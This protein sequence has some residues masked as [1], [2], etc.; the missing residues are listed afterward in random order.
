MDA[1]LGAA[2]CDPVS[3][4][5][6]DYRKARSG[7][8]E[9]RPA[10]PASGAS[11]LHSPMRYGAAMSNVTA[12]LLLLV[13]GH[14]VAFRAYYAI[15]DTVR[16]ATG[17]PAHSFYGFLN[18]LVRVLQDRA[19]THVAVTLDLGEPFRTAL[20]PAYK[21]SRSAGP[22]DLEPQ[23]A[24]LRTLL[25]QLGVPVFERQ[26]FEAD[27][28]LATLTRQGQARG[29]NVDVLS[30]D[31]DV[32][33]LVA[34]GVRIVTPGKTFAEPVVYDEAAVVGRYGV[35]P[36]KLRDWKALVGDA[37]DEI[38]GVPGIGKKTATELLQRYDSL[39]A[40][41]THLDH[42]VNTRA[43]NA[44]A[45]GR[46]SAE[47]SRMLVTLRTDAPVTLDLEA[48]RFPS[49]APATA[50]HAIQDLGFRS[51]AD[52]VARLAEPVR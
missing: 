1:W 12:P 6:L 32:L 41:Y 7:T 40:I 27:D 13:D 9:A 28:L 21:S 26:G 38:P 23:V 25:A 52:R 15:P 11:N 2:N 4:L 44:L 10:L 14:S 36:T 3:T 37:S 48:A 19:P 31:F 49:F 47:L 34:P 8:Q 5:V 16:F 42:V 20:F 45:E 30:G 17:E 43:R 29:C 22:E 46:E 33:Q 24:R 18:I 35:P 51:L 50:K 39:D